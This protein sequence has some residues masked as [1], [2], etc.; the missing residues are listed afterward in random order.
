S[1]PLPEIGTITWIQAVAIPASLLGTCPEDSQSAVQITIDGSAA[2]LALVMRPNADAAGNFTNLLGWTPQI[3]G[4]WLLCS[5]Q[6]DGGGLTLARTSAT[7]NVQAPAAT[8]A[9]PSA[10]PGTGPTAAP[11]PGTSIP[12]AKPANVERPRVVR[13][14]RRL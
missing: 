3:P 4:Q 13:S 12:A 14:G 8:Q 7:V 6:S 10:G 9:P 5:Y 1:P 11:R 2:L